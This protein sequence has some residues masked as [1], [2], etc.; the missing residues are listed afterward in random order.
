MDGVCPEFGTYL[1]PPA[2]EGWSGRESAR[3]RFRGLRRA[4]MYKVSRHASHFTA[5]WASEKTPLPLPFI[6]S[7]CIQ[8]SQISVPVT[9]QAQLNP[10]RSSPIQSSPVKPNPIQFSSIQSSPV[11]SNSFQSSQV[12]PIPVQPNL[13]QSNPVQS[14]PVQSSS[15]QFS[16][17]Q[18]SSVQSSPAQLSSVAVT[19]RCLCRSS[20]RAG[21]PTAAQ[22][23]ARAV[24][25]SGPGLS[26]I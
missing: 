26:V 5:T 11:Q 25:R 24:S 10:I 4:C 8:F 7:P 21:R 22:R 9:I 2:P 12:E 13:V 23:A 20:W 15:A 14:S 3:G 17:V 18:P 1:V 6:R 19:G 16:P